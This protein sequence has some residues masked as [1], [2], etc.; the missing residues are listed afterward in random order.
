MPSTSPTPAR[1][2]AGAL[3]ASGAGAV[4][5]GLPR[6]FASQRV[7]FIARPGM[8]VQEILEEGLQRADLDVRHTRHAVVLIGGVEISRTL[9]T[10][11]RPRP[12]AELTFRIVPADSGGGGSKDP[13]RAILT[14]AVIV[15]AMYF[16][17]AW[18]LTGAG[19]A[20]ASAAI[21]GVG[22]LAVNA[23]APIRIPKQ[24]RD[25]DSGGERLQG[26][27][28]RVNQWGTVPTLFGRHRVY[29]YYAARPYTEMASY[30]QFLRV[31]L[32]VGHGPLEIQLDSQGRPDIRIGETPIYEYGR[33]QVE[34]NGNLQPGETMPGFANQV[35]EEQVGVRL[36]ADIERI[37]TTEPDVNEITVEIDY[38]VGLFRASDSGKRRPNGVWMRVAYRAVGDT[39]WI[40]VTEPPRKPDNNPFTNYNGPEDEIMMRTHTWDKARPV[41]L[42]HHWAVP[43]G[44][45]EVLCER[46]S[47]DEDEM[48][49]RV[50]ESWWG[51]LRS[52]RHVSPLN[53]DR[54]LAMLSLRI[55]ATEQLQGVLDQVNLVATSI[56]PTWTGTEWVDAPTSNPASMMR[57]ALQ[58]VA[59]PRPLLD[60]ALDLEALASW[61]IL[62]EAQLGGTPFRFNQY[63]ETADSL[64]EVVADICAAGRAVPTLGIDGRWSVIPDTLRFNPVQHVTP[65]NSW[66]FSSERLFVRQPHAWRVRF[67]NELMDWQADEYIIY[68]EGYSAGNATLF[69]QLELPGVTHPDQVWRLGRYLIANARLRRE[70]YSFNM[71]FE[72]MVFTRG[73][74]IRATHDVTLWGLG[75]ARIKSL[76]TD[77]G[78]TTGIVLDEPIPME[79]D[80]AY[81]VRIRRNTGQQLIRSVQ[82]LGPSSTIMLSSPIGTGIGPEVG[83]LVGFGRVNQ[84]SVELLV[85]SIE[86]GEHGT[87]RITAIDYAPAVY[88]SDAG[89]I[90]P[91]DPQITQPVD[92][93]QLRPMPPIVLAIETGSRALVMG[94]DGSLRSRILISATA[95]GGAVP[96]SRLMARYRVPLLQPDTS[97]TAWI[98]VDASADDGELSL[99]P[100]VDGES[101]YVEVAAVSAY[102]IPS[103]WLPLGDIEVIGQNEPPSPVEDFTA[104]SR[105][106][107]VQLNWTPGQEL[108]LAGYV[109]RHGASWDDGEFVATVAHPDAE[110]IWDIRDAG[111]YTFWIKARDRTGN[112]SDDAVSAEVTVQAPPQVSPTVQFSGP[113]YLLTWPELQGTF[114]VEEYEIRRGATWATAVLVTTAKTT[115]YRAKADFAGT[116]TFWVAGVDVAGNV[117]APGSVQVTVQTPSAPRQLT[118]QVIDNNVLLRWLAPTSGTLPIDEYEI[119]R[120]ETFGAAETVGRVKATFSAIFEPSAGE[121]RYWSAAVDSAGNIGAP[122]SISAKVDQPP[123]YVLQLNIDHDIEDPDDSDNAAVRPGRV[124]MP[125]D[126]AETWGDHFT[127]NSWSTIEDQLNAGYPVYAQPTPTEA[128]WEQL[129]DYGAVLPATRITVTPNVEIIAG[130]ADVEVQVFTSPDNSTWTDWTRGD[131]TVLADNFRYVRVRVWV[132]QASDTALVALV[133][134]NTRLDSKKRRDGGSGTSAAGDSGGTQVTFNVE[135]VDIDSITVTPSGTAAAIAI[136]DF[137]DAPYPTEFFVY[138]FDLQGNRVSGGFSWS[139]QGV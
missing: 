92:W 48:P 124:L 127:G 16:P 69:E 81:S 36:T 65:R 20:F 10:R 15:A 21:V 112:L 98:E 47:P 58:G 85:R 102:G 60:A 53:H 28:N 118:A 130:T 14:I 119:R 59:N 109:I 76:I 25:D 128:Y 6:I 116:Q 121:H 115:T 135:F 125:V 87:A 40:E 84:E 56:A 63:R 93:T 41:R 99:E 83:N 103:V 50:S 32:C 34:W 131:A 113:D 122:V 139:A 18:G 19:A 74:L 22:M 101:Y 12:G 11:I 7:E 42:A 137:V 136:Y 33:V 106:F 46:L 110:F 26:T 64:P 129:I 79:P 57:L 67:I 3:S 134:V 77:G 123:D 62:C 8:T 94:I 54:P 73:D 55:R 24:P 72:H 30:Q 97:E 133:G 71:D 117:G 13:I 49:R 126:T 45:Y 23:L 82:N 80:V 9:W 111:A 39:E 31:L 66:G 37:R 78:N 52:I 75:A 4:V 107:G 104:L 61:Y 120:G 29:P 108:D 86:P 105:K 100:V 1:G 2:G 90:P 27:R 68:D 35:I 70:I 95:A 114:Q 5:S 44:Q 89:N 43:Q 91:F 132:S 51:V 17:P 138:L 96:V 38:P 88:T